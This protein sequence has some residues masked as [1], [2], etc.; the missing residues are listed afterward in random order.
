MNLKNLEPKEGYLNRHIEPLPKGKA[1]ISIFIEGEGE[2][3]CNW[4]PYNPDEFKILKLGYPVEHL[5]GTAKVIQ[6][7]YFGVGYNVWEINDY[8]FIYYKLLAIVP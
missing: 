6:E 7:K 1:L 5:L 2:L 8:E 3:F 4:N